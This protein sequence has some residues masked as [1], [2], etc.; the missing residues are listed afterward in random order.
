MDG[1][2]AIFTADLASL[3]KDPAD[4]LIVATAIVYR[5]TLMTADERLLQW[6]HPVKRHHAAR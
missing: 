2:I 1:A 6:Q 5:A 3:H 4:R